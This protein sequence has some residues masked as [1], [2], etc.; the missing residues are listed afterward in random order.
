MT[1]NLNTPMEDCLLTKRPIT[2]NKSYCKEAMA[3]ETK[4]IKWKDDT[5]FYLD[6]YGMKDG[7]KSLGGK[8]RVTL[9]IFPMEKAKLNEVGSARQEPNHSPFCPPPIGRISFTLNPF[10]MFA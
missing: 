7:K 5:S 9:D 3:E 8:V 4:D 10:K 6:C 2:L 1:L